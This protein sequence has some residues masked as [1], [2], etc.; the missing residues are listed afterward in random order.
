MNE[1]RRREDVDQP[2]GP[3]NWT[4]IALVAGL[5]L[6]VIVIAYF[7]TS[8][9][10]EQDKL[11]NT[12]I[13]TTTPGRQD[14]L[15]ASSTTYDLIKAELFRRAAKLR[16]S[17]QAVYDRL[18]SYALVRMENPVME[19]QD[20]STG[21][22][23][24]SGSL[25]LDLPPGV[26]VAGGRRTLASDVDYTVQQAADGTGTV[27]VL[28]NADA[29]VTPLST[30]ARVGEPAPQSSVPAEENDV[31][32]EAPRTNEMQPAPPDQPM[33]RPLANDPG[34]AALDRDMMTEYSHAFGV[35]SPEQ[36]DLLR[37][38]SRRFNAFRDS[39]PD[40]Q[41]IADAYAGRIREIRDIIESR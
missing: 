1:P 36:R 20:N 24:C 27:V 26:A 3:T 21:A 2:I 9:S 16:G 40:R 41:C 38:T 8:R 34:L 17:D 11:T 28:R 35:A 23:N 33:P 39:C 10:A 30:L 18:A 12:A 7:A 22:V 5:I 25:S 6:L 31:T 29:I 4:F 19:S 37:S 15:C 14:K 32:P 13:A